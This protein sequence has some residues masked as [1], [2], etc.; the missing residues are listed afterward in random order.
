V[1]GAW[2]ARVES[3]ET[4]GETFAGTGGINRSA[5]ADKT[6]EDGPAICMESLLAQG[7]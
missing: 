2:V 4:S 1:A 6:Y 3:C 7:M 5:V